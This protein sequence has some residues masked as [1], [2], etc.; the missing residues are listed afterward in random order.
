MQYRSGSASNQFGFA[1][2]SSASQSEYVPSSIGYPPAET[3]T[4]PP[5]APLKSSWAATV[6]NL[7]SQAAPVPASTS[8]HNAHSAS[9]GAAFVADERAL[10]VMKSCLQQALKEFPN[11]SMSKRR[12]RKRPRPGDIPPWKSGVNH[13]IAHGVRNVGSL[14]SAHGKEALI[15]SSVTH[16][17]ATRDEQAIA[18]RNSKNLTHA[19]Q[20]VH[21]GSSFDDSDLHSRSDHGAAKRKRRRGMTEDVDEL[22]FGEDVESLSDV[23]SMTSTY[24]GLPVQGPQEEWEKLLLSEEPIATA[25]VPEAFPFG[26]QEEWEK[27]LF[28]GELSPAKSECSL[29]T[30]EG[31][32]I[33]SR[34][35]GPFSREIL[36]VKNRAV[37]RKWNLS[38]SPT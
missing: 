28:D 18:D 4:F 32:P 6:N 36:L 12:N 21:S 16:N 7:P 14:A 38:L 23:A 8:N 34:F 24:G 15:A 30:G 5:S 22:L 33:P 37:S 31:S 29:S 17:E 27:L 10:R 13:P 3:T 2:A 19:S 9:S 20:R 11:E 1:P 26:P 35:A 25:K